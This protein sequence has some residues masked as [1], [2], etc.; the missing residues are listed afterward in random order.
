MNQGLKIRIGSRLDNTHPVT[1]DA[2]SLIYT[3]ALI[4]SN[5]GGGK[6]GLLRVIAEQVASE[7]PT[8]I[9]DKEGEFYTLREKVD[10]VLV[11]EQGEIPTDVRSAGLLAR[12]LIELGASAVIDLSDLKPSERQHEFVKTF[13]DSLIELPRKLWHP[14]FVLIDEAHIFCPEE[15][16]GK[17]VA[18]QSVINLM[19][20]G[21]KRGFGGI[22]ATQRLS[23]LHKNA[24]DVNNVFIGR[25]YLDVDQKRA[26]R[27]LGMTPKDAIIL[28]DCKRQ[29]FYAF[30][31]DV[32]FTGVAQLRV[33]DCQT[34]MPKPGDR[35]ALTPPKASSVV[36]QIAE[37]LKDIPAQAEAEIRTFEDAKKEIVK[38]KRE[39]HARPKPEI[40][41]QAIERAVRQA[42]AQMERDHQSILQQGVNEHLALRKKLTVIGDLAT[43]IAEAAK[44]N[45]DVS[46]F[47]PSAASP[48]SVMSQPRPIAR[49]ITKHSP[50]LSPPV[51]D[52][53]FVP[54][55][56]QQE[57]LNALAW[58]ESLGNMEP[59]N[60]Q[61]GAV[62]L[63]DSSGGHFSNTMGPLSTAGLVIRGQGTTRL[64]EAGRE[65][66]EIPDNVGTLAE[67]HDVLR[68]RIRK[69]RSAGGR[70]IDM[71]DVIVARRGAEITTE[72]IGAEVGI[73]HTGGHFSNM[74][75]PLGTVGLIERRSGIVRPTE[76]LFPPGLS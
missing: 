47:V 32:N 11:G 56:K 25:T 27:E 34:T 20:L 49:T 40:D 41:N 31:A 69:M 30:G 3:R 61:I 64:T 28:R 54:S 22:L 2:S 19:T 29:E 39:L 6:S 21:R 76:I 71:F 8:I 9:I 43:K 51:P 62:A 58:F 23:K 13:L 4:Q 70:T 1:L 48:P 60:V 10:I 46:Q 52:G 16:M 42:T 7:I 37:K 44:V 15:G 63:I 38:L 12:K 5:S 55:R 72:E 18:T 14:T 66:A 57:I 68:A 24:A 65:R 53:D 17:S 50:S 45:G 59:S 67:Y 33:E 75:G 73:D 36:V 74:I 35:A 26:A